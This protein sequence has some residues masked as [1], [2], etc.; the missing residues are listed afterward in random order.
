M[1]RRK[2]IIGFKESAILY[3]ENLGSN[4]TLKFLLK[5]LKMMDGEIEIVLR[6]NDKKSKKPPTEKQKA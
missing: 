5:V 6:R 2:S 3:F 1:L 4:P